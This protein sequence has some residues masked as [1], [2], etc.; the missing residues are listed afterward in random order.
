MTNC[1][2]INDKV[3]SNVGMPNSGISFPMLKLKISDLNTIITNYEIK[4]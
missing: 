2:R 4:E 3:N 1:L